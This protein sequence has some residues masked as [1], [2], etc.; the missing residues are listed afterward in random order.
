MVFLQVGPWRA[1]ACS[2]EVQGCNYTYCPAS[3][4]QDHELHGHCSQGCWQLLYLQTALLFF[5]VKVPAE[6]LSSLSYSPPVSKSCH[7]F[8]VGISRTVC[9]KNKTQGAKIFLFTLLKE[10]W[11][12]KWYL[13]QMNQ[14]ENGGNQRFII[15]LRA[16]KLFSFSFITYFSL[17]WRFASQVKSQENDRIFYNRYLIFN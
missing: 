11:Q 7:Q 6:H 15:V 14:K 1:K 5:L 3:S 12:I 2:P 9:A 4:M 10:S 16:L 17:L 8:S 13:Q